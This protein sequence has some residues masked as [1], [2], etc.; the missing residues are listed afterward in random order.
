[1]RVTVLTKRQPFCLLTKGANVAV[2]DCDAASREQTVT[3]IERRDLVALL[4]RADISKETDAGRLASE[5]TRVFGGIDVL[6]HNGAIFVLKGFDATVLE[7]QQS[8]AVNVI[9]TVLVTR[10]VVDSIQ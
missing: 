5:T 10:Y 4:V 1:M 7:W 9:G 6:V 2:V 3:E 8:L